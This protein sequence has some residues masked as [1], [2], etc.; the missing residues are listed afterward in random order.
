MRFSEDMYEENDT[1]T[2]C[3][4]RRMKGMIRIISGVRS[5]MTGDAKF[6]RE[7]I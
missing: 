4:L 3:I 2:A 1:G 6:C 7:S 5:E